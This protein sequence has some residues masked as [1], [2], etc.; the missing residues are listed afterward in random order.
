[1]VP[2]PGGPGAEASLVGAAM[3]KQLPIEFLHQSREGPIHLQSLRCGKGWVAR[4]SGPQL[5]CAFP[6]KTAAAANRK[7]SQ[8]FAAM[9]PE[10]RCTPRCGRAPDR[11]GERDGAGSAWS[12]PL[13]PAL[14]RDRGGI[15]GSW[16]QPVSMDLSEASRDRRK[17]FRVA[18]HYQCARVTDLDQPPGPTLGVT[19]NI[20]RAGLLIRWRRGARAPSLPQGGGSPRGVGKVAEQ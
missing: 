15:D 8:S 19:E 16:R 18:A 7:L 11:S 3:G 6:A 20:S 4:I 5:D 17:H 10:H 13:P 2:R 1:V 9:F 12:P 14:T